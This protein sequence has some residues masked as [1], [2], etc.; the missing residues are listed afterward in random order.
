MHHT[1]ELVLADTKEFDELVSKL[2][3]YSIKFH[4]DRDTCT[5]GFD[6]EKDYDDAV[7]VC[8]D[9]GYQVKARLFPKLRP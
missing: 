7:R 4:Q 8:N 3:M 5:V 2:K 9:L 6:G 1:L